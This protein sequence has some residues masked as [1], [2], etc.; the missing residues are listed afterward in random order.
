MDELDAANESPPSC[1]SANGDRL[2]REPVRLFE[3]ESTEG[4]VPPSPLSRE[5][6]RRTV[7]LQ[8]NEK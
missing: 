6:K 8:E 5:G 7:S 4:V 2:D 3:G 1:L